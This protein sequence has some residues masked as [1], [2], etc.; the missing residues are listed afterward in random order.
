[1]GMMV[2]QVEPQLK[3]RQEIPAAFFILFDK[4]TSMLKKAGFFCP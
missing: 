1:M 4:K 2:P 3:K